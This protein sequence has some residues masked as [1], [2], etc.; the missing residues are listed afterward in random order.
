MN[1]RRRQKILTVLYKLEVGG[2]ER[3]AITL[4]KG[5]DKTKFEPLFCCF[6][7]GM[8]EQELFS[9]GIQIYNLNK[10]NGFDFTLLP[11]FINIIKKEKIDLIH[12]HTFSPNLWGRLAGVISG[13]PVVTTEHTVA[14]VKRPIQK[15]IDKVLSSF[16]AK[17]VAVSEVVRDSVIKEENILPDKVMTIYNGIDFNI[18]TYPADLLEKKRRELGINN[19]SKVVVAI[20][21]LEEPKG[22]EYLLQA[23]KVILNEFH[24]V[25]LLIV[26]DGYLKSELIRHTNDLGIRKDVIFSGRRN[27][28]SDIL[29]MSDIAVLSSIREGFS[30]ALLEYMACGKPIV[31]TDVGGNSEAIITNKSGIIVPPANH[32]ALAAGILKLLKDEPFANRLGMEAQKRY[33]EC[34]TLKHMV[35]GIEELYNST[36]GN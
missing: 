17:I 4:A 32:L 14:A 35:S 3:I 7:G 6:K 29:T 21:R 16:S 15:V 36:L 11:R 30:I 31:A 25:Q 22:H 2:A 18:P 23:A 9:S 26:G 19:G 27:D 5:L 28:I 12:T 34:F 13:V 10:T 33:S 8:L 1:S 24:N 20:G